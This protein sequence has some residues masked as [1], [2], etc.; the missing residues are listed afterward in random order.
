[1]DSATLTGGLYCPAAAEADLLDDVRERL[2][3]ALPQ[4]I[5]WPF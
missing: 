3:T 4:E 2:F 1:M 5:A